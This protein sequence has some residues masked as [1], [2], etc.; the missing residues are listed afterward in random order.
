MKPNKGDEIDSLMDYVGAFGRHHKQICLLTWLAVMVSSSVSVS[1]VFLAWQP[2]YRCRI[3]ECEVIGGDSESFSNLTSPAEEIESREENSLFNLTSL[4]EKLISWDVWRHD[5]FL[6]F[7]TPP[8]KISGFDKCHQYKPLE[9]NDTDTCQS[10]NFDQGTMLSCQNGITYDE[11]VMKTSISEFD[12]GCKPKIFYSLPSFLIMAGS[13]FLAIPFGEF[14]DRYGRKMGIVLTGMV[15]GISG[16]VVAFA[17]NNIAFLV[18]M[19]FH[20][21]GRA[22]LYSILFVHTMEAVSIK[23]RTKVG[24]LIGIPF[25]LGEAWT[26]LLAFLTRDWRY[27]QIALSVPALLILSYYWIYP[28]SLR[29]LANRKKNEAY[30][31][32]EDICKKNNLDIPKSKMDMFEENATE[33]DSVDKTEP[34]ENRSFLKLVLDSRMRR[35]SFILF[36]QWF[37]CVMMYYGLSFHSGNMK[38]N[39]FVDFTSSMLIEIP[40]ITMSYFIVTATGRKGGMIITYVMAGVCCATAALLPETWGSSIYYTTLFGK[41]GAAAAYFVLYMYT[42]EVFP[43]EYRAVASGTCSMCGRVGGILTSFVVFMTADSP[44]RVVPIVFGTM[45]IICSFLT[46]FL[47]ETSKTSL[48]ESVEEL[49]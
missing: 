24:I 25:A 3:S 39:L 34:K 9:T 37:S 42:S 46:I 15:T 13:I 7:T 10:E 44:V 30:K 49:T 11:T 35:T 21:A 47:P 29:W 41:S 5:S 18:G 43:T 28:E 33:M 16:M 12:M 40:A 48:P 19:P 23:H 22:G 32:V 20:G 6:N 1:V 27:L 14:T 26:G 38:G 4:S 2:A 36:F 31:M 8:D 45:G 17:P